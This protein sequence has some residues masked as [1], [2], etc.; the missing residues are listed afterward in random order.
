MSINIQHEW[1]EDGNCSV[2]VSQDT[3]AYQFKLGDVF[4]IF[5]STISGYFN[6]TGTGLHMLAKEFFAASEYARQRYDE[7][8]AE[9]AS[10]AARAE[11]ADTLN[12][13]IYSE[14]TISE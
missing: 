3:P 9:S 8:Q 5:L 4:G 14:R 10:E 7:E 6:C 13:L 12:G 11:I 1:D 2:G